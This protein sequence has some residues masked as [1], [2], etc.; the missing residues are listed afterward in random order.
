M[1]DDCEFDQQSF[2]E[3]DHHVSPRGQGNAVSI[4]FNLLYHW[5]AS[6]CE[7]DEKRL[8]ELF[9]KLF[10]SKDPT[11]VRCFLVVCS[12][13]SMHCHAGDYRRV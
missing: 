3:S 12:T 9:G 2:R 8:N 5:H 10:E 13:N 1:D 11:T 7:Q 6:I 4:E